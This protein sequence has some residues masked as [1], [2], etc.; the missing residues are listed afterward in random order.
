MAP[1]DFER[2]ASRLPIFPAVAYGAIV[3][4]NNVE[5]TL[6]DVEA[7]ISKDQT[8]AGHIIRG[9]NSAIMGSAARVGNIRQAVIRIGMEGARRIVSAAL[10]RK[11]F[12]A[13]DSHRLWNHSLD[14]A[15]SAANIARQSKAVDSGEAFLAGL[16]HDVGKLV[17]LNLPS[18]AQACRDRLAEGGCPD[19]VV[20]RIILGEDHASIGSRLLRKWRFT[21]NLAPTVQSHH[22]PESNP[23]PLSSVVYLAELSA[24]QDG[25]LESA[26]RDEVARQRLPLLSDVGE[27]P[28]PAV[29]LT[30]GL[31][32]AMAA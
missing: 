16:M 32:F 10:L 30:S 28:A 22:A 20:E 27:F 4:F 29:G 12:A 19:P 7:L 11:L 17:I 21:E 24:G 23:S 25:G 5:T 6:D 1:G 8:L 3:L 14:V 18:P 13:K 31:R 15:E 2:A 9:A 26:W